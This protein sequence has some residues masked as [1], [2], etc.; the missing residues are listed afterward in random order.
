MDEFVI[1]D[2]KVVFWIFFGA[3][4]FGLGFEIIAVC[5]CLIFNYDLVSFGSMSFIAGIF[6]V[7]ALAGLISYFYQTLSYCDGTF[8]H[9]FFIFKKHVVK[10]AVGKVVFKED[11]K[12]RSVS[13][14]AI[15][16]DK[17]NKKL[18]TFSICSLE[19]MEE[20]SQLIRKLRI[21]RSFK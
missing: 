1:R 7:I 8:S 9:G 16:Y 13:A 15:F 12:R 21:P 18:F 20:V 6:T 3:L 11:I 10:E 2:S 5:S 19:V 14:S 4:L 17:D